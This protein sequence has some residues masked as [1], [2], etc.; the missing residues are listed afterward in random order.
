MIIDSYLQIYCCSVVSIDKGMLW[1]K[2]FKGKLNQQRNNS[3][4]N[5]GKL[6]VI[7]IV[8]YGKKSLNSQN[9]NCLRI[10]IKGLLA[11]KILKLKLC[12]KFTLIL[13]QVSVGR[14]AGCQPA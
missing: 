10:D 1:E 14:A 13:L 4:N 6:N 2:I 3:K 12:Q 7:T 5:K 9:I 8:V 11:M